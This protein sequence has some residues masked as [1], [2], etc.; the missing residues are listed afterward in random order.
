[1]SSSDVC[2]QCVHAH[3]IDTHKNILNIE[4]IPPQGAWRTEGRAWA[5][6][7]GRTA[8]VQGL[9]LALRAQGCLCSGDREH[10]WGTGDQWGNR[11]ELEDSKCSDGSGKR[12]GR[13]IRSC[14]WTSRDLGDTGQHRGQRVQASLLSQAVLS[15]SPGGSGSGSGHYDSEERAGPHGPAEL[16]TLPFIPHPVPN[17]KPGWDL[18]QEVKCLPGT[19]GASGWNPSKGIRWQSGT[20]LGCQRSRGREKGFKVTLNDTSHSTSGWAT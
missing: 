7:K 2:T 6:G 16:H 5:R 11:E 15:K 4:N 3:K 18:S 10:I 1:M 12:E 19:C 9:L 14:Y 8:R 13:D 17:R 20:H